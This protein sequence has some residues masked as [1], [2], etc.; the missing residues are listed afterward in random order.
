MITSDITV[1]QESNKETATDNLKTAK[2]TGYNVMENKSVKNSIRFLYL[3]V[4]F[5]PFSAGKDLP[6]MIDYVS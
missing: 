1:Y 2:K 4:T 3:V 5:F 6:K